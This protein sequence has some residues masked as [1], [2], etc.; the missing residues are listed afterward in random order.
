MQNNPRWILLFSVVPITIDELQP[1]WLDAL[2]GTQSIRMTY[3]EPNEAIELIR[4]PVPDFPDIYS[5]ET[6]DRILYWTNR[7]PYLI[8]L[9]ATILVELLNQRPDPRKQR[10]T[11]AD[12]DNIVPK[13][14]RTR[15]HL[16]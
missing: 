2:I 14:T 1:Y 3:L 16:L 12:I 15:L 13:V 6:V 5:D 7:Q 4:K 9:L 10:P 11:P 8:Q